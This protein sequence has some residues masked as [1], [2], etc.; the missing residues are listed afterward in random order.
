M[1]TTLPQKQKY[2]ITFIVWS[3]IVLGL[4]IWF[5]TYINQDDDSTEIRQR[6]EF[7][8]GSTGVWGLLWLAAL[9]LISYYAVRLMHHYFDKISR[10]TSKFY[11]LTLVHLR[12]IAQGLGSVDTLS[13]S[14][15]SISSGFIKAL[16]A[17]SPQGPSG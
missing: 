3:V 4:M 14:L 5:Q 8:I 7:W 17:Q 1:A 11:N 16:S 9:T 2:I 13:N 10:D 15:Q 6:G 12:E